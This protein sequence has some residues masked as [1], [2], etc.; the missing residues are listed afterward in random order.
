MMENKWPLMAKSV[1]NL[2][3]FHACYLILFSWE[4]YELGPAITA[5]HL[6]EGG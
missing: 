1:L 5:F 2:G 4:L 3:L 6:G